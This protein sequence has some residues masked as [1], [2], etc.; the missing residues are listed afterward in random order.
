[1]AD[2]ANIFDGADADDLSDFQPAKPKRTA[3]PA[4][5]VREVAAKA[6]FPSREADPKPERPGRKQY[7]T[8]RTEQFFCKADPKV[9]ADFYAIANEQNWVM[10]VTLENAV[11][12]LKRE[13]ARGGNGQ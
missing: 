4:Q 9:V 1:M 10:G 3:P 13:L 11:A 5:A 8:G 7:R 2:R 6:N 12:A